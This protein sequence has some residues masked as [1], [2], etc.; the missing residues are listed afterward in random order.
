M[1]EK[2]QTAKQADDHQTSRSHSPGEFALDVAQVVLG[3]G[4]CGG[5]VHH[6]RSLFSLL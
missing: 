3:F 1:I 6:V 5:L 4:V 2:R